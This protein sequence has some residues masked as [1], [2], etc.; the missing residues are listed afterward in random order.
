MKLNP[1]TDIIM[2][3]IHQ[4][5]TTE[6]KIQTLKEDFL[7]RDQTTFVKIRRTGRLGWES[8]IPEGTPYSDYMLSPASDEELIKNSYRLAEDMIKVMDTPFK[9]RLRI[10][11]DGFRTDGKTVW[12]ATEVFDDTDLPIGNRIDT[13]LGL[14]I[15][16]KNN[17]V[18]FPEDYIVDIEDDDTYYLMESEALQTL[19]DFFGID[20]K[21]MD[22]AMILVQENNEKDDGRVWVNRS[23]LVE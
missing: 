4:N 3:R 8:S 6:Q 19:S 11:P 10:S 13:F 5:L 9:V 7:D 20:F 14:T 23:Q 18:F 22:E 21:D 17:N 2:K 12:V 15:Y 1:I 16:E